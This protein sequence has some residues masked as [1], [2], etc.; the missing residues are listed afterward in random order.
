M[1][2][3]VL[4]KP[5][6]LEEEAFEALLNSDG[7]EVERLMQRGVQEA[8]REHKAQG[9]P[10]VVWQDGKIVWLSPDEIPLFDEKDN[11]RPETTPPTNGKH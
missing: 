11:H 5:T 9:V 7:D 8:L 3:S 6:P 2:N 4:I 10:I 1:Q